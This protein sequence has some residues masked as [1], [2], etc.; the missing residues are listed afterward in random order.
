MVEKKGSDRNP[1]VFPISI[2]SSLSFRLLD[3]NKDI[4]IDLNQV[5]S[6]IKIGWNNSKINQGSQTVTNTHALFPI[7]QEGPL[8]M[9]I[10]QSIVSGFTWFC[11]STTYQPWRSW[12][13]IIPMSVTAHLDLGPRHLHKVNPFFSLF[14][15]NIGV[16]ESNNDRETETL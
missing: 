5:Y 12:S 15:V 10:H 7:F 11:I 16:S 14:S 1:E 13:H 9:L 3:L 2:F 4:W 8:F 6:L